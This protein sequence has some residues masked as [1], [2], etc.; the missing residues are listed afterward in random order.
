MAQQSIRL[1]QG[2]HASSDD[3]FHAHIEQPVINLIPENWEDLYNK[4]DNT[5]K[6]CN[7]PSIITKY[8]KIEIYPNP[9]TDKITIKFDNDIEL[10]KNSKIFITNVNGIL[11]ENLPINNSLNTIDLS[12]KPNGLYFIW[13]CTEKKLL[14]YKI[15]KQ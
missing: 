7:K 13:I 3:E 15:I 9:T 1:T 5:K 11:I 14:T 10:S 6:I 8:D 12:D 2:F 4:K